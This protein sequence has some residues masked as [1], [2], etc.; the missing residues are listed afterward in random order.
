VEGIRALY[1]LG[2][3]CL[4]ENW[5]FGKMPIYGN[6]VY[7]DAESGHIEFETTWLS[8]VGYISMIL[9]ESLQRQAYI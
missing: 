9:L 3:I 4:R 5:N 1:E 7:C 6:G 8:S 2:A